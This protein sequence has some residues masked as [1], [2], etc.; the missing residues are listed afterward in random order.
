MISWFLFPEPFLPQGKGRSHLWKK[1]DVM[2]GDGLQGR[3]RR[4][5]PVFFLRPLQ[6]GMWSPSYQPHVQGA[7]A[8]R[9]QEGLEEPR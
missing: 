8:A 7:M 1:E 9:V 6:R 3:K 2:K 4:G 5:K